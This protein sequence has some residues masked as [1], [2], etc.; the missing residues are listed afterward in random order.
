MV[1][2]LALVLCVA[3][4]FVWKAK[5]A[6]SAKGKKVKK[7]ATNPFASNEFLAGKHCCAAASP[8][9]GRRFL[10]AES[11]KLP[12][13]NCSDPELCECHFKAV[14]DR[15]SSD[16][17]RSVVGALSTEMPIGDE[18]TNRRTG[19]DRRKEEVSFDYD[20]GGK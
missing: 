4:F 6:Q 1:W 10:I 12:L 16:D 8:L 17:R 19:R 5:S 3:A 9:N 11:P 20:R 7:P 13:E 18:R 14:D 2:V 15:R